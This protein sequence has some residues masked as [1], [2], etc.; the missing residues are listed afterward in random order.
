MS[1]VY[2][3]IASRKEYCQFYEEQELDETITKLSEM[4]YL[5]CRYPSEEYLISL[6]TNDGQ[7]S[8]KNHLSIQYSKNKENHYL[9]PLFDTPQMLE[10]IPLLKE[11]KM[12]IDGHIRNTIIVPHDHPFFQEKLAQLYKFIKESP[13]YFFDTIYK[14]NVPKHL[15]RLALLYHENKDQVFDTLEDAYNYEG[16]KRNLEL[17]FSRYKTF[18]GYLIYTAKYLTKNQVNITEY[19]PPKDTFQELEEYDCEEFLTDEEIANTVAEGDEVY[20]MQKRLI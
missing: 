11:I 10:I 3:L 18:R 17:E 5:T 12:P 2:K 4:D 8:G 1:R 13:E 15:K 19:I 6:L 14:Q 16:I 9:M 20:G 7:I